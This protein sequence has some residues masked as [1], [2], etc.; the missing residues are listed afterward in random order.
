M[1]ARTRW[2]PVGAVLVAG[3]F[4]ALSPSPQAQSALRSQR[5]RLYEQIREARAKKAEA[6][7]KAA[8]CRSELRKSEARLAQAREQLGGAENRIIET[9]QSIT[10]TE[11]AVFRAERDLD[12]QRKVSGERLLAMHKAGGASLLAVLV[13]AN[14]FTDMT[15]RAYVYG[16]LAQTDAEIVQQIDER[17]R[18]AETLKLDLEKQKKR[19]EQERQRIAEAKG[20]IAVETERVRELTAQKQREADEWAAKEDALEAQSRALTAQIK[21]WTSGGS[22]YTGRWTGSWRQ[23]APG[24][25]TSG[26]GMRMH[27]ILHY[28]RMHTG[29]DIHS[30]MGA[31]VSAAGAGKVVSCGWNGGYGNC[32]IID[33]G[34]G[35]TTLYA[36]M[37][38]IAVTHGQIVSAGQRVGSVGST[39]LSTGPHLHFEVR[40][41]GSPVNPVA[42]GL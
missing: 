15:T 2:L 19:V 20:R 10:D 1:F 31:P 18:A 12:R 17:R 6:N 35:R 16:R 11:R 22:G 42:N 5:G 32:V 25:I 41:N 24:P 29:V 14:D 33:H 34:G 8:D 7:A 38:A 28:M 13:G 36:H 3:L 26:F 9:R 21:A 40:V 23:P 37:S 4:A 39:G 27:P 30:P